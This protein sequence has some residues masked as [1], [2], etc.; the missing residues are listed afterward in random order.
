MDSLVGTWIHVPGKPD[1]VIVKT[2]THGT[3]NAASVLGPPMHEGFRCL[4]EKYNDGKNFILHYVTARELYN[5]VKA[6]EAGEQGNP[7]QFRNYCVGAP[8]YDSSPEIAE[9]SQ[10][11]H[12]ALARTYR[13]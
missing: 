8:R 4:E 9:A 12:E 10:E 6:A 11:L 7:E 1:W 2:H 13:G 3:V 5:I